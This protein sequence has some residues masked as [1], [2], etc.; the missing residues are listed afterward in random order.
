MKKLKIAITVDLRV[1]LFSNGINQNGLYLAMLFQEMGHQVTLVSSTVEEGGYKQLEKYGVTGVKIKKIQEALNDYY[2]VV[3]GLGLTIEQSYTKAWKQRNPNIKVVA[4]KCGNEL[5]TD[6]ETVL[7]GSHEKRAEIF[8]KLPQPATPDQ[9][10]SIPQMENTNLDYYSFLLHQENATVVPFVWDPI[11]IENYMK[12]EGF[13]TWKSHKGRSIAVMEPNL[14]MMKNVIPPIMFLDR[15]LNSGYTYDH[16]YLFSTRKIAG[17]KRFLKLL[18]TAK[19]KLA[20]KGISAED[21]MPTG[22]VLEKHAD[23][24]LS[25]QIENNLNYLYFDVAWMGYPIVH[26]ANLCQDIG[27]YYPNQEAQAA[28]DQLE[29]AFNNH[30][31]EYLEEQRNKI[32]RYTRKNPVLIEQ[33]AKLLQDLVDDKF[34][35]YQYNWQE[36]RIDN[37]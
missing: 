28:A 8:N 14:S 13:D 26:N 29:N 37:L 6:V 16:A 24:V 19:S 27:Y 30:N 10:W 33:Y 31:L 3:I 32:S 36:N 34:T 12:A 25:W 17:N 20:H 5:F 1:S 9:I 11:V 18:N 15:F 35:K 4:Y 7:H 21:R 23:V 22:K 2:H